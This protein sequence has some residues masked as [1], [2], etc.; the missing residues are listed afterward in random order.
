LK[1]KSLPSIHPSINHKEKEKDKAHKASGSQQIQL[2][3]KIHPNPRPSTTD[4][5]HLIESISLGTQVQ[6]YIH[7]RRKVH[8]KEK[9]EKK[10]YKSDRALIRSCCGLVVEAD[11]LSPSF[12]Y[13]SKSILE[14]FDHG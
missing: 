6:I 4:C 9:E 5:K 7:A 1:K 13:V 2:I 14:V 11:W 12:H 10:R 8:T 3:S